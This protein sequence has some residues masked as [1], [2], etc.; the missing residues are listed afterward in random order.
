MQLWDAAMEENQDIHP[1]TLSSFRLAFSSINFH[2]R[3]KVIKL[4]YLNMGW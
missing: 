3:L 4:I 2:N 1:S